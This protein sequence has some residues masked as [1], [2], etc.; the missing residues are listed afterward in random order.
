M[1]AMAPVIGPSAHTQ[2]H[3]DA[4]TCTHRITLCKRKAI[5]HRRRTS[6]PFYSTNAPPPRLSDMTSQQSGIVFSGVIKTT[7]THT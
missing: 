6:R 3:A 5:H 7:H 1:E 4:H 2:T